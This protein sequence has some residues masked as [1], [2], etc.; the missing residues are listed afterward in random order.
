MNLR[1][2]AAFFVSF[3][4]LNADTLVLRNGNRIDGSFLGGDNRSIRFASGNQVSTYNLNDITSVSFNNSAADAA[5]PAPVSAPPPPAAPAPQQQ[6]QDY[7]PPSDDNA[8]PA[9][10]NTAGMQV[11]SGTEIT[12]R[13]IDPVN[14]DADRLGQT[15]RASIDSPVVVNGQTVI[16]RGADAV[17]T[18]VDAQKSGRIQGR[19][20][21]TLDLK[22]ITVNGRSYDI[23]TA[24]VPQASSSRTARSAKVIGGTAALGAIIGAIAGGGKGAAIGTVAGAGAGTA[25]EVATSGQKVNIP[26]ETR[27]TFTLKNPLNL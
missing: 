14:S 21:M 20:V 6:A 1:L 9:A 17:A 8:P 11:A 5:L 19:T 7:P 24:G 10:A 12:V 3:A 2:G 13:L 27:L 4:V 23:A 22:S 26:S 15:Y 18:L 25:A 16:A